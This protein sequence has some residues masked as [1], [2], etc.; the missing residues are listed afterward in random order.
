MNAQL[1]LLVL[2]FL[3]QLESR[4][5]KLLAWG[6]VDGGFSKGEVEKLAEEAIQNLDVDVDPW[7]LLD[8]M[9]ERKLLFDFNWRG[10]RLYRTRMAESVRLFARLRQ[11]F[12]N[13]D[14]QTSPTLVADY[15][16]SLRQRVYP[17]REIQPE[18]VVEQLEAEK[19]LTSVRRTALE[20]LL[21][22]PNRTLELADF[23]LRATARMLRD[24]NSTKSRGMI[25][26]AGTGTGKTLA[27]YLPALTHIAE[28]IKKT[29][30]WTKAIAIYPRNELLKD[31]FSE[32]YVE[33]RRLDAALTAQG[34]RKILIGAFFG[35]TPR[36]ANVE[37]YALKNDW[38]AERGGFT[39]PYIRCPRCSGALSWR[40]SDLEEGK[41]QLTCLEPTCGAVIR[42]D[43]I[44]LTRDRMIQ[45][46]P[47]LLFT[48]TEML[49]RSLGDSRYG[50]IF[51]INT[52]KPPHLMLLDEVHT[53]VGIHGA[54]VAYLL[55]R[56]Q[57]LIGKRVQFTGLSATLRSAAEFFTQLVGLDPGSVEEISP[58]DDVQ[59][60][61]MEYLLALRGDPVSGTSLLSTSIQTAMLLQRVLD[62]SNSIP[63]NGAYGSRVFAFT[64]DLDVTNRLFHNLLDAEGLNSFGR[65]MARRQPLASLRTHDA[66]DAAQRLLTGQSWLLC[67]EI[68]HTLQNPLRVT[69]TSSQDTGV[70]ATANLIVATSSLEV[71]FN[72]PN[73]GAVIQ[74][75]APRDMASFLQRKGRAGRS[76][77][78]RPW[79]VVVLSDYG[80]DR[81]AYQSYDLLFD[82]TL[83]E[84]LLPIAN[85]YVIRIQAAFACMDWIAQQM[86]GAPQGSIWKDFSKPSSFSP[87]QQ[88][89]QQAKTIIQSILED[90]KQQQALESYLQSALKISLGETQAILWEPPRALMT[91]VLPTLLRRL[92]ANWQRLPLPGE[93]ELDYHTDEPL[94]DFVPASLFSDLLLPEVRIVTPPATQQTT[95]ADEY[96]LPILQAL[97]AFA[98]GRVS[99]R[100][101]VQR[102]QISHWI[103]SP[104]LIAGHQVLAIDQYC[105]EFE[106]AGTFQIWQQEG[107]ANIRCIRPWTLRVAQIPSEVSDKSNAQLEWH[108][109]IVPPSSGSSLDLPQGSLWLEIVS[110]L[111]SFTHNQQNPLEVRRFALGSQANL[112]VKRNRQV[113]E[114]ETS[115]QFIE[116]ESG[117]PAGVGFA[118]TV[119]GL[120]CRYRIPEGFT[121]SP[122]D[123]NRAKVYSFRSSYFKHRILH[124][125]RLDGIANIFQRGWLHQI[126]LSMLVA[127]ALERDIPLPEAFATLQADGV[128]QAMIAV[129][130][131]IFQTLAVEEQ[132]DE[133]FGG[134]LGEDEE[135]PDPHLPPGRQPTHERLRELCNT[136]LIQE[137]LN[138]LAPILWNPPDAMWDEWAKQRRFSATLGGALLE[139]C[140]QL[141]PQFD[142]GDLLLDLDPGPRSPDSPAKPEGIEEIWLTEA[143]PGGSGVIE[144][145]LQRYAADPA[146]FFRLVESALEPSDFEIIDSELTNLLELTDSDDSICEALAQVRGAESYQSLAIASENLRR[147]LSHRGILVTPTVMTAIHARVLTPGS[148]VETD[149]QLLNLI[150]DWQAQEDRLGIE[151]DARVFAYIASTQSRF[152]D[153]LPPETRNNPYA[154]FQV[155]YGRL[156]LRGSLI[157]NRAI[158]FYNPFAIV[159]E[160]DREILLDVLQPSEN[161]VKLEESNWREQVDQGLKTVG[162]VSLMAKLTD[163]QALK[164][165]ALQ[166]MTEPVD[167]GFLNVYPVV[168]GFRRT[169]QGY[170]VRLR[171]REAVQ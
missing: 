118:Q 91:A 3:N 73:V 154:S 44:V 71:G 84:R 107:V 34:Q 100:F 79:T 150:R 42:E 51:G 163:R 82:P 164:R 62:P 134:D 169:V 24:L 19:L 27:F 135:Q 36:R 152:T 167:V 40:R 136:L 109:Q 146:G 64:D 121:I 2:E 49:N 4:E 54:Q 142:S 92:E 89:Q 46:P 57:Q 131:G 94:P 132:N 160:A 114:L 31:Q 13:R 70:D 33:A 56:W 76:R 74:H 98:P 127:R 9:Q 8:E 153:A 125:P 66:T 97:K 53:Y 14:W 139:A 103:A 81:I 77:A 157:R 43:E 106:E 105:A 138:D 59:P 12:P 18:I 140:R 99:R 145:I 165:A 144:E 16:F 148:N 65:P 161:V 117:R 17:K 38:K 30:F 159:P 83:E 149:R 50:H 58:S 96:Y 88:R 90:E 95:E 166:L 61:G 60:E 28:L 113:Q 41:E 72:D 78:M 93:P 85:R 7:D 122:Y 123:A 37:D 137:V 48:T 1:N 133:E 130:D 21:R 32:T 129:L 112:R 102:S 6:V 15:R 5:V 119:D 52:A 147:T 29:T 63:S 111:C 108:T 86:Q 168:E 35:L 155:L 22:S 124:D 45:T 20:A 80:R 110:E 23:Q 101:G 69:R 75:K 170:I 143:S 158:S 55:R 11:L 67:E 120:V 171:I 68:G 162:A 128:G 141:C 39:C 156:W 116:A 10:R 87:Q 25:V 126:Y 26:C 151:I 115:I 104:E 47:D